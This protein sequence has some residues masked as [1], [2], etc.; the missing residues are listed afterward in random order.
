MSECYCKKFPEICGACFDAMKERAE[1]AEA[2]NAVLK[3]WIDKALYLMD[4]WDI[5]DPEHDSMCDI[6]MH[7]PTKCDCYAK[8]QR[9]DFQKLIDEIEKWQ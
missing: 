9:A 8:E 7:N 4:Y 1:K 5:T 3:Q 6:R 2:E